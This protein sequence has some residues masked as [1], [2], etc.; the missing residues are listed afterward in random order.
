MAELQCHPEP[1]FL[2][3][4]DVAEIDAIINT[5]VTTTSPVYDFTAEDG[6]QHTFG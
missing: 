4:P 3:Y 2:T 6:I 5:I 1:V